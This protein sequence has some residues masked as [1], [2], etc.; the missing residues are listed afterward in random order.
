MNQNCLAEEHSHLIE[1]FDCISRSISNFRYQ[2]KFSQNCNGGLKLFFYQFQF[3][4][5]LNFILCNS[6]EK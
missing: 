1:I 4:T 2:Q 6:V 3:K 5:Q